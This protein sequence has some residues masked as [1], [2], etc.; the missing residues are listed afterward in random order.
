MAAL[1]SPRLWPT[2]SPRYL[3][4]DS[5]TV[6]G[7]EHD[8]ISAKVV[9]DPQTLQLPTIFFEQPSVNNPVD[10]LTSLHVPVDDRAR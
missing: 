5:D 3:L 9:Y 4:V 2:S 1:M 8:R 7:R 10:L 6:A